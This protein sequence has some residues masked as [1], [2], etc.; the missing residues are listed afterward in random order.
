MPI[1]QQ[2]S[3]DGIYADNSGGL[4]AI[5][6]YAFYRDLTTGNIASGGLAVTTPTGPGIPALDGK[7]SL[8]RWRAWTT[9]YCCDS[10]GV[11][12]NYEDESQEIPRSLAPGRSS[13]HESAPKS[14]TAQAAPE[15]SLDN[16]ARF[17]GSKSGGARPGTFARPTMDVPPATA[18]R[19]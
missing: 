5:G 9:T 16:I 19:D 10:E 18:H 8:C 2:Q 6:K 12:F 1:L 11:H 17:F 15:R 14:K 13:S 4:T 3:S 7:R